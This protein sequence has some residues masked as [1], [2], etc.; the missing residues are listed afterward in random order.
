MFLTLLFTLAP[1]IIGLPFVFLLGAGCLS[2]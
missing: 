1:V 2:W